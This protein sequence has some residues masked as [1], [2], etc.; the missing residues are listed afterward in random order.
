MF[1]T[2]L[3]YQGWLKHRNPLLYTTSKGTEEKYFIDPLNHENFDEKY[4]GICNVCGEETT[5]GIPVKKLLGNTYLDWTI[6]KGLEI[7]THICPACAFCFIMNSAQG[8][9]I[10]YRYSVVANRENLHICNRSQMRNWLLS[11]P[12]PPF[13]MAITVS[14]KKHIVTKS[15][16][17]YSKK[18]FFCNLEDITYP[19]NIDEITKNIKYAELLRGIGINKSELETGKL[20][21]YQ[22]GK[23]GL[24]VCINAINLINELKDTISWKIAVFTAGINENE[25]ELKCFTD[26]LQKI[27][28]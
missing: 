20:N 24:N 15:K 4:I 21:N 23:L 3:V 11:P 16:V 1:P 18:K 28:Q 2:K 22:L 9:N 13:V 10:L 19:V 26:S 14:Q 27:P 6:H 12:D 17:S 7:G 5:G 25:E 8:K